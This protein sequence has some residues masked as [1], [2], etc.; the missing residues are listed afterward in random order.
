MN[1]SKFLGYFGFSIA[2]ILIAAFAY[3]W[4]ERTA[5][6]RKIKSDMI[7]AVHLD[8]KNAILARLDEVPSWVHFPDKERAE[9]IN[10]I[11]KQVWPYF[12]KYLDSM[13]KTTIE[14]I[15]KASV[16]FISET[17]IKTLLNQFSSSRQLLET[18]ALKK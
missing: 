1:K 9:W 12:I 10:K 7:R 5:N 17:K 16:V 18:F 14:P 4:R 2:W 8:E 6:L 11:L 15:I 3:L 13:F